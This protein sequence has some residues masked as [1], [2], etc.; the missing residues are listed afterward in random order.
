MAGGGFFSDITGAIG[1][2]F[3]TSGDT[4]GATSTTGTKTGTQTDS[5]SSTNTV[6][7]NSGNTISKSGSQ[8]SDQTVTNSGSKNSTTGTSTTQNSGRVDTTQTILDKTAT[9]RIIQQILESTSGLASITSG[10]KASGGYNS[11]ATQLLTDDLLARTAG[12][13]AVRGAKTVN[14]IGASSSTTASQSDQI[15]GSST[16]TTKGN[17]SYEDTT[18]NGPSRTN[19]TST[20]GPRTVTSS[21]SQDTKS[22]T[23]QNQSKDGMLGWIICTELRNQGRMS[24]RL[25]I[26]G[27]FKFRSYDDQIKKGYYIWAISSTLHLRNNPTSTYSNFLATVFNLRARHIAK[28]D[29]NLATAIAYYGVHAF[30]Y[31]LSRTVARNYGVDLS[32]IYGANYGN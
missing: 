3:G 18:F 6:S 10:A 11:S 17:Q 27:A 5:G 7:D 8:T 21:E 24:N 26:P 12:E 2:V 32:T 20:T 1:D 13:V 4:N 25:Y 19:T 30:C 16:S 29:R 31:V 9:D 22:D 14:T 23:A 28:K 15:L